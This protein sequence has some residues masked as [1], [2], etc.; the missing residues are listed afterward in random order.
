VG[1]EPRV[2]EVQVGMARSERGIGQE[3]SRGGRLIRFFA[4]AFV[5]SWI[6]LLASAAHALGWSSIEVP[7][8]GLL[9]AGYGPALAAMILVAREAGRDGL[10]ELLGRL[11]HWRIGLAWY[12]LVVVSP[13]A[14]MLVGITVHV[15]LGEQAPNLA[16]S[17][18]LREVA[19][20]ATP[21][22]FLAIVF[23]QQALVLIG[24]EV[25]WR[26]Y[27]LPALQARYSALVASLMLG[28]VW[29]LWHLPLILTPAARSGVA[30]VPVV[31][32][33]L[34]IVASSVFYAWVYNNTRGSL[35]AVTLLHT[36]TNTAVVFLPVT[37]IAA[38]DVRPFLAVIVARWVV[39]G[40]ILVH[41]GRLTL[42]GRSVHDNP[43]YDRPITSH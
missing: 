37:A 9:I 4:L 28:L 39:V 43:Y 21:L 41:A 22:L 34:D 13:V 32:F 1:N 23:V 12:V 2:F 40:L 14:F 8:P 30:D 24:E 11:L 10:K 35:F 15:A 29:G 3:P 38:T 7:L 31:L 27:A 5:I 18:L 17:P 25:G 19:E 26:G 6:P 33:L 16:D 42:M 36:V 20:G